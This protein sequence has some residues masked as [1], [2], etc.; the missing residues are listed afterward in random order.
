ML[1]T[2]KEIKSQ[3]DVINVALTYFSRWKIEE[4]FRYKKQMFRFENFRVRKLAAINALNFY[5][6]LCMTF[7]AQISIKLEINTL[8]VSIIQKRASGSAFGGFI[9]V[10]CSQNCHSRPFK[11]LAD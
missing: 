6:T 3:D 2:N 1:A 10:L 8:K 11:K 9:K 5:I 7:L 4:Y